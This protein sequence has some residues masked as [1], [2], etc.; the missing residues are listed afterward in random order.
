MYSERSYGYINE[1]QFFALTSMSICVGRVGC[2]MCACVWV[3]A[4]SIQSSVAS[5]ASSEVGLAF[6]LKK[7]TFHFIDMP[8]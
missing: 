3:M 5:T 8:I 6:F 2:H 1:S 4:S 7:N